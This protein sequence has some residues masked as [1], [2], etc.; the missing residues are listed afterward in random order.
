MRSAVSLSYPVN[1][2]IFLRQV[3]AARIM[4]GDGSF[5]LAY[6]AYILD[7]LRNKT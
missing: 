4:F 7:P 6:M 3:S 2:K 5:K 1:L